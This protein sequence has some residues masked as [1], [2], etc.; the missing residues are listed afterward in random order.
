MALKLRRSCRDGGARKTKKGPSNYAYAA[1][2]ATE[3]AGKHDMTLALR[4]GFGDGEGRKKYTFKLSSGC[5]DAGGRK[6]NK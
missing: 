5:G 6:T 1:G 3:G 4:S 2:V